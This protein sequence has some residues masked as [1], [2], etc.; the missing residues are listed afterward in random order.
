MSRASR[1]PQQQPQQ[2]PPPQSQDIVMGPPP[3]PPQVA[4]S[5]SQA[6]T[7][8]SNKDPVEVLEK[9]S[10]LKRRFFEMEEKNK[11]LEI[12]VRSQGERAVIWRAERS[13]LLERIKEL[14]SNTLSNPNNT[15]PSPAFTAYP[16]SLLNPHAQKIFIANLEQGISEAEQESLDIDPLLMS[17]HVGPQARRRHE[18]EMR[19]RQEEE[20]REARRLARRP[21]PSPKNKEPARGSPLTFAP[22]PPQPVVGGSHNQSTTMVLNNGPRIRMKHTEVGPGGILIHDRSESPLSPGVPLHE[23]YEPVG[24]NG[25][26]PMTGVLTLSPSAQYRATPTDPVK[27]AQS[28]MQMTLRPSNSGSS[29]RPSEVQR[30]AKPK[31]LKAHTVQSKTFN[32]P[33][34]PRDK[35]G[36]PILPL[37]VGIMTVHNLGEVCM[38][39]H[40]HTERYIFPVGYEVQRRYLSTRDPNCE[41]VYHCTILD[42]GDGPKFQIVAGDHPDQPV[43]AGTATGAWSVI[44]RAANNIRHRQHSNSVSG[45]DFFGLGQNTIKHLIQQLP[46]ANQLKDYVWQNFQEGGP[47]GGRHAAV[48]PAL[49]DEHDSNAPT[50][51]ATMYYSDRG[52]LVELDRPPQR[53]LQI[54]QVDKDDLHA[55]SSGSRSRSNTN[56]GPPANM[57]ST[58]KPITFHQEYINPPDPSPPRESRGKERR[59]SRARN[60]T[61]ENFG[62]NGGPGVT[63]HPH[64]ESPSRSQQRNASHS[65]V[66]HRAEAGREQVF[67]SPTAQQLPPPP[68]RSS[69]TSHHSHSPF[70]SH[71]NGRP[72]PPAPSPQNQQPT[73][74]GQV[75][76]TFA[77]IMHA[78]P[79]PPLADSPRAGLAVTAGMPIQENPEYAFVNS[80]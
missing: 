72:P 39:E 78:Y 48:I 68:S 52:E 69:S 12:Q 62:N 46:G 64:S 56:N 67:S 30:H 53:E 57:T 45:P 17:R 38:R 36:N 11:D 14:E 32:I 74:P 54:I 44:V 26:A 80:R 25:G 22:V 51:N 4:Y 34:V 59:S 20:A 5:A 1:Q 79:V 61:F 29:S 66:M 3:L 65:P 77:S 23:E 8:K 58:I 73:S 40:F 7:Q 19:E 70:I 27:A 2:M 28:Q 76:A 31:R 37:N 33:M 15:V 42:G 49:P 6:S 47:L 16:R 35:K 63:S 50:L 71:N 21:K 13:A 55:P 10:R 43:V 60:Q 41:V 24:D 18:V 9:Y 75:P